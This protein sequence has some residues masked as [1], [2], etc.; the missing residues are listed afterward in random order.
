MKDYF[1]KQNAHQSKMP[2]KILAENQKVDVVKYE[3]VDETQMEN[4]QNF[5]PI[6]KIELEEGVEICP[7]CGLDI[8]KRKELLS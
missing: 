6:C 7:K 2:N 1:E 5:C 4:I 8:K 3:K